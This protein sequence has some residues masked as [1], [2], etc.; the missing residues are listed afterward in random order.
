[1][2]LYEE[3]YLTI[4]IAEERPRPDQLSRITQELGGRTKVRFVQVVHEQLDLALKSNAVVHVTSLTRRL[5]ERAESYAQS[6]SQ[7]IS[8]LDTVQERLNS[9]DATIIDLVNAILTHGDKTRSTDI[10]LIPFRDSVR[11]TFRTD[12]L[13]HD[14]PDPIPKSISQAITNR[15]KLISTIDIQPVA[16][17]QHGRFS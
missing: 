9:E 11:V 13:L 16:A 4:A 7:T 1:L 2:Y 3:K 17:A 6:G 10:H 5:A 15:I 14:F 12:T 8:Q